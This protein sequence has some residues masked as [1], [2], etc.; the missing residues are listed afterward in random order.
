MLGESGKAGLQ[1]RSHGRET[2][3]GEMREIKPTTPQ[4]KCYGTPVRRK[5]KGQGGRTKLCSVCSKVKRP[6]YKRKAGQDRDGYLGDG[7]DALKAGKMKPKACVKKRT[8]YLQTMFDE[9]KTRGSVQCPTG[10]PGRQEV[11][12]EGWRDANG[13][14]PLLGMVLISQARE[15]N[16][17]TEWTRQGQGNS[18]LGKIVIS[19]KQPRP[20]LLTGDEEGKRQMWRMIV[21]RRVC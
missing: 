1:G 17:V 5:L 3:T 10:L 11:E 7:V 21:L 6:E 15:V 12:G 13:Q 20:L 4:S 18:G 19:R 16:G 2:L 14:M 9:R 8:T